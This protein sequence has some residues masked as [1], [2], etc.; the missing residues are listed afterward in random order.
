MDATTPWTGDPETALRSLPEMVERI[1]KRFDPLR[2]ILFG[3]FARGEAQ[4]WSDIDL[5]V[6][7]PSAPDRRET[8]IDILRSLSDSPIP[9][10]IIV[11]DP[12]QIARRGNQ[13]GTVLRPALRDGKVLYERG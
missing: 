3:S 2:I 11:T 8:T 10:D 4:R 12:E 6:I 13:I 7:L 1:V 5:L 9:V